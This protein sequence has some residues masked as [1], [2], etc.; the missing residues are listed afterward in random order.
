MANG[1]GRVKDMVVVLPGITGSVLEKD[2]K[3]IWGLSGTS[4]WSIIKTRGDSIREGLTMKGDDRKLDDLGDGVKATKLIQD[5][6]IVPGL[7]KIDGYSGLR[8]LF[9]DRLEMKMGSIHTNEPA[10]FFE[11]PYDWRRYNAV[12]AR[13]LQNFV[14]DRLL[15]WRNYSGAQDA[16]VILVGH[17]MG[18]MISRYYLEVLGGWKDCKILVTFG[19]PHRGSVDAVGY[20][21]NGYKKATLDITEMMRSLSTMYEIMPIYEMVKIDDQYKRIVETTDI[22]NLP[23]HKAQDG[24]QFLDDINKAVESNRKDADYLTNGYKFIPFVGTRQRTNQWVEVAGEGVIVH[25]TPPEHWEAGLK[26]LGDGDGTVPRVSAIPIEFSDE[27][28]D[29]YRPESHGALQ[30]NDVLLDQ[31]R[32]VILKSQARGLANVRGSGLVDKDGA[33]QAAL[34]LKVDDLYLTDE[35]VEIQADLYNGGNINQLSADIRSTSHGDSVVTTVSLSQTSDGEWKGVVEN[36]PPGTYRIS[37]SA[38]NAGAK[39]PAVVHNVFEVFKA[40]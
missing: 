5:T 31:L 25:Q 4:I 6:T 32:G 40:G 16:K 19:T 38:P 36:L 35:P 9:V 14:N 33:K 3:E 34:G 21:A 26:E 29:T 27:Y 22:P 17:S 13:K 24:R 37:L 28:R 30:N 18:G 10:N 8:N 23:L 2:G 7:V 11:F 20:M 1:A 39:G 15:A 12:T